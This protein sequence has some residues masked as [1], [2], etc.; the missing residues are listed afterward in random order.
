VEIF[1]FTEEDSMRA[2]AFAILAVAVVGLGPSPAA[3]VE[4]GPVRIHKGM[5]EPSGAIAVPEGS[6]D[7]MFIIANDEDNTVRAY[8]A[9]G[10]EPLAMPSGNLNEF[11]GLD[12]QK[13]DDDKA[14]FEGA[15]WLKGKTYWIGSH[16]RSRKGKLREQ[17]RQ[18]FSRLVSIEADTPILSRT[19]EKA[20]Q[21]L[22]AAIAPLDER[23]KNTIRLDVLE[24]KS[25]APD[26]GGFNIEGLTA[27]ADGQS[28]L[29]GLRS[30]LIDGQAILIPL[31]NPEGVAEKGEKPVVGPLILIALEKRGVRSIEYSEAAKAYFI[32]A[33][34]A[35]GDTG[36]FELYRWPADEKS[37]PTAVPGFAAALQQ[38]AKGKDPPFKPEAMV[39]GSSGKTLH[40]FSDDGDT[41]DASAPTFRSIVVTLP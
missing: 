5:C 8:R 37:P 26:A 33:G 2:K 23:L 12:P 10:G 41:C 40:L 18:F 29:I 4:F 31:A 6:V 38:V 22:L 7:R 21:G 17:R 13:D 20:F 15:T 25:L 30:P 3:G 11:L 35:G 27:R 14:D 16:S 28:L 36:T 1:I 24:D 32:V 34:P 9:G 39:I 19:S